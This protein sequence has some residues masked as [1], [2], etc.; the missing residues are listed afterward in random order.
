[1]YVFSFL[2]LAPMKHISQLRS[3]IV[4]HWFYRLL[5]IRSMNEFLIT[6]LFNVLNQLDLEHDTWSNSHIYHATHRKYVIQYVYAIM[7]AK[8][9]LLLRHWWKLS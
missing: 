7:Q 2:S 5:F 6:L 3:L 4:S 9:R 8:Q 1:M